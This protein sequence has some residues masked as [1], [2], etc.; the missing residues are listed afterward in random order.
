MI[1]GG[2]PADFTP[3]GR[4][5]VAQ[6][7][8]DSGSDSVRCP[9]FPCPE[10]ESSRDLFRGD[11]HAAFRAVTLE[12]KPGKE[13]WQLRLGSNGEE[14]LYAYEK[15]MTWSK[16]DGRCAASLIKSFTPGS[17]LVDETWATF[18]ADDQSPALHCVVANTGR[19]VHV[20]VESGDHFP[21]APLFRVSSSPLSST[22]SD[23]FAAHRLV[24]SLP[25]IRDC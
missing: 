13:R 15:T 10:T 18:P 12:D 19:M 11:I 14:E 1:A 22:C 9:A 16:R 2:T 5:V 17:E 20:F 21:V 6:H 23:F 7:P 24:E 25:V 3:F 4:V 8:Q